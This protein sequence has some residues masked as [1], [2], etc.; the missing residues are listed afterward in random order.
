MQRAPLVSPSILASDLS[1]P[2]DAVR[3]AEKSG[4]TYMHFDI[5][6]GRFVPNI[7]FGPQFVQAV[8]RTTKLRP[9]IHLMIT[10]P[11][12]YADEFLKADPEI[13]TFHHEAV[14]QAGPLIAELKRKGLPKAGISISPSTPVSALRDVL[15]LADLVLVMT[16]NPGF[17]GQKII[18]GIESKVME[19][20]KIRDETGLKFTIEIDG[21]IDAETWPRF[22]GHV[23]MVVLGAAFFRNPDRKAFLKQL[24]TP[25]RR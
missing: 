6:D 17:Y 15:P 7:T 4:L 1:R 5:M 22:A 21:G 8:A 9:D 19:L 11:A 3:L 18:A 23:D 10:D 16:V 2:L 24:K 12:R 25:D 20:D 14:P 13:M